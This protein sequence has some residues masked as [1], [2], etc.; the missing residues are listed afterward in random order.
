MDLS[1]GLADAVRQLARAS[2]TGA[3]LDHERVPVNPQARRWFE[4]RGLEPVT[5][6][7][8]GGEDY[9]LLFAVPR[10]KR[11][12]FLAAIARSGAVTATPFGELTADT[13]VVLRRGNDS[14]ELPAGF[15]HLG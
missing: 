3:R 11:R 1:D 5:A 6:A 14:F 12:A 7:L 10:K 15:S 4:G 9:E 13:A 2:G 8:S